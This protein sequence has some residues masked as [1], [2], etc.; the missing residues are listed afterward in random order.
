MP[1]EPSDEE[2]MTAYQ[3]G[4]SLAFDQIYARHSG[5]VLGFLR[6]KTSS[7][8][9]ARDIFQATFL[10]FHKT[11]ARYSADFPLLPW[12]FT[13]CRNE[14]VDAMRKRARCLEESREFLPEPA[15]ETKAEEPDMELV[16]GALQGK[17][18]EALA[19]RYGEDLSFT[20]IAERLETSPAN[21]R[22]IVS[23]AVQFLRGKYEK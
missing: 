22:K 8:A 15:F 1:T 13:L 4:D 14:L 2:L 21:A 7:D 20:Q 10:K 18:R 23:R 3:L 16:L 6:A 5:R 12:L 11:R 9:Q 17:Q 19:L